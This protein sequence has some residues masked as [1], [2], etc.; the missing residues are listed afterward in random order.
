V[1]LHPTY[2]SVDPALQK[3]STCGADTAIG[4]EEAFLGLN[5]CLG[6]AQGRDVEIGQDVAEML[7]GDRR[8]DS[9]D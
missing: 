2:V 1:L 5:K 7:L 8:A 9:A 6:L 3:L 4:L